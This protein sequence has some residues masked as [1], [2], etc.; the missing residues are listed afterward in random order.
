MYKALVLVRNIE[1]D[2]VELDTGEFRIE[3]VGLRFKE[4]REIFASL[5]VDPDHWIFEKSYTQLPPAQPGSK[6]DA[7]IQQ[8]VEESLLLLRLYKPGDISFMKHVIMLP[9]SKPYAQVPSR[10]VNDLNSR[11]PLLFKIESHDGRSW[12]AFADRIR[13]T[14]SWTSTW[15]GTAR[16]F[17]LSGGAKQ[18]NPEGDEVDRVVDY[19]TALEATLVP[20]KDYNARRMRNR[21]AA[22]VASYDPEQREV[23]SNFIKRLY[24]IRSRIVHGAS[25]ADK[26]REWLLKNSREIELRVREILVAALL[27]PPSQENRRNSLARLYDVAD[28]DRGNFVVEKFKEIKAAEVR[29]AILAEITRLVGS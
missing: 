9:D 5:D 17:F 2:S 22:L 16:R 23:V 11:S 21:A 13:E 12:K 7:A 28:A 24:D 26:D 15:F 19:C 18:F 20:E 14:R 3:R 29:N 8:D 4:L 25:I 27:Q 6:F 10:V 1:E